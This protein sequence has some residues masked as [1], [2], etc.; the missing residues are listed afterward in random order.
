MTAPLDFD[1]LEPGFTFAPV[2]ERIS[3]AMLREYDLAVGRATTSTRVPPALLTVLARRAY[4]AEAPMP[5]G[6][7]LLR[8][9]LSWRRALRID[10]EIEGRAAV[11][12]REGTGERR[13]VAIRSALHDPAGTLFATATAK[14]AWPPKTAEAGQQTSRPASP[15]PGRNEKRHP[16]HGGG[17]PRLSAELSIEQDA[18]DRWADLSGDR[19]PL[20]LD[21]AA[22]RAAGFPAP[23]AHGQLVLALVAEQLTRDLGDPWEHR[24]SL[25]AVRFRAPLHPGRR[26][27]LQATPAADARPFELRDAADGHLCLT[28]TAGRTFLSPGGE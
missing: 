12:A 5:P 14:I 9:E 11:L 19:N 21:S 8:Q 2:R 16:N 22:A 18:I 13:S 24:G 17:T 4:L 7:L 15:S 26:Y 1:K 6:G 20:H 23:I 25:H 27:L 10:E 28:G 3:A